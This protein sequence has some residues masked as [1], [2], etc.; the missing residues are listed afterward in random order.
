M[1]CSGDVNQIEIHSVENENP[2]L[3]NGPVQKFRI[4]DSGKLVSS[5]FIILR[6]SIRYISGETKLG[7]NGLGND[8]N[9]GNPGI[10]ILNNV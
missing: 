6:N 2:R 5:A 7:I 8:G 4:C 9:A 10:V 1:E 3:L